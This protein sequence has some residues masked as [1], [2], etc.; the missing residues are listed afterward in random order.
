MKVC[1]VSPLSVSD[2]VDP[3]LT[4]GTYHRKMAPQLGIL[5]LAAVL[6]EANIAVEIVNIDECFFTFVEKD[7]DSGG[8]NVGS[9]EGF[10]EELVRQF[11]AYDFD[12]YGFGSICSSY[13]LTL[14]LAREVKRLHPECIN[15]AGGPQASVV[16]RQTIRSFSFVDYVVRGEADVALPRLIAAIS[17]NDGEELE[18]ITGI[19][20]RRG[21]EVIR[22]GASPV[23]DDLDALPLPAF[24][25]D[26]R[27]RERTGAHLEIGR[28]CPFA[29]TFCSTN[30]FFRRN[31]RLKSP[32]KMIEQ[33]RE[34]KSRYGI[35]NFSL[36]HDMYTINRKE[37]VAFC[38][39][40]L[41][42]GEGF[43]WSCSARTDCIDDEL[44]SLMARAGC[45]GIFFGIETGSERLQKA[46]NKKLDLAAAM[47]R[48]KCADENGITTAVALIAAFP[49]ETRDDLRDTIHYFVRSLRFD[50]AEPQMSLLAPLAE[51]P[52][53]TQY[54]DELVFDSIFSD[55]SHQGW[56]QDPSDVE[57]IRAYPD[58]FPNFYAIPT[59]HLERQYFREVHDFV[60]AIGVW[61]R[62]LPVALVEDSGDLLSV[63]DRWQ[64]WRA[65]HV[66][67]TTMDGVR[68]APYYNR[69]DFAIDFCCFIKTDYVENAA[70]A[71]QAIAAI[72]DVEGVPP[73]APKDS[74]PKEESAVAASEVSDEITI[75]AVPY[76]LPNVRHV[77]LD[78]DYGEIIKKLRLG[79]PIDQVSE[80]KVAV[81]FVATGSE[82]I[83]VRQLGALAAGLLH[84]CDGRTAIRQMA[85]RIAPFA[86]R[87][88]EIPQHKVC[89]YALNWLY[90]QQLIGFTAADPADKVS[91]LRLAS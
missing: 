52:L 26:P 10:F 83:E 34:V 38:E 18:K 2:F 37:V 48:I 29:C 70:R 44:I 50:H 79:L 89:L 54:Q 7:R 8:P 30:D 76:R 39:T 51:T 27:V 13:P 19:T 47:E 6:I 33:M 80:R 15:I 66:A 36:V 49:D 40:L 84:C 35:Q 82:A 58:I 61:F 78:V 73:S 1:L 57:L 24:H 45:R 62:W 3:E 42:S 85:E 17:A 56:R 43:I 31:F 9:P 4:L 53:S 72:S 65:E 81:V 32:A 11:A 63:F 16:D 74:Q 77:N 59:Q 90:E 75:D 5:C 55:M 21:E 46:I 28:G 68:K 64:T 91:E 88:S 41:E 69:N 23:I 87:L 25:L 71:K 22:N 12:V 14:R 86:P 20:Y 67:T 60:T